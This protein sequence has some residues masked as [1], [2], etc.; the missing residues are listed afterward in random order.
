MLGEENEILL[1]VAMML[2]QPDPAAQA[3]AGKTFFENMDEAHGFWSLV[4]V[5]LSRC[6]SADSRR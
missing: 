3:D 1:L 6:G 5:T 4:V 2:D